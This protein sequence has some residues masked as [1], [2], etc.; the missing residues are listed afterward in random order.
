MFHCYMQFLP[1]IKYLYNQQAWQLYN[2]HYGCLPVYWLLAALTK[3]LPIVIFRIFEQQFFFFL[4]FYLIFFIIFDPWL[5][6]SADIS[7]YLILY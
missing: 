7:F 1:S 2:W 4:L 3:H 5:A 6:V